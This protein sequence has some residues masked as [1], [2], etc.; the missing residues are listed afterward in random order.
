MIELRL[1]DGFAGG[2]RSGPGRPS[3]ALEVGGCPPRPKR[4]S[5]GILAALAAGS[6][7]LATPAF[8]DST[9]VPDPTITPGAVRTPE[10]GEICSHGTRE[11]RSWSRDRDDFILR[12]Y[13]PPGPHPDYEVDHLIPLGIGGAD[14]DRNLWP[15]PRRSIES[16]WSAERKGRLEWKV[17]KL[18]CSGA[19]DVREA[20]RAIADDWTAAFVKYVGEPR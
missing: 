7:M 12:E 8:A 15:E 17:R 6:L 4:A 16:I 11:L 13:L 5:W 10:V 2:R 1:V 3:G 20:Q 18:V 19:L 9:I 14:D